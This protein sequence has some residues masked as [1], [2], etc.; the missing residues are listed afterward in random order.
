MAVQ[1]QSAPSFALIT[2]VLSVVFYCVGFIRVELEI[3]EQKNRIKALESVM[4]AA[5]P[6]SDS[7][8]DPN[9]K[10]PTN[11]PGESK[12]REIQARNILLIFL[13]RSRLG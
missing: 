10:L 1:K 12:F 4:N 11:S 7:A 8:D 13:K 3:N 9:I 6:L 5:N 2:S